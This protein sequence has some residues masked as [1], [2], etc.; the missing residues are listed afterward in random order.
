MKYDL[1]KIMSRAWKIKEKYDQKTKNQLW[2][3][4]DFRELKAEETAL[5]SECLKAAWKE[6]KRAVEL[7]NKFADVIELSEETAAEMAEVETK[8]SMEECRDVQARWNIWS[9]I[10]AY[11]N[12]SCWSRYKNSKRCNYVAL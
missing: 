9:G 8:V 4:N 11:Y 1:K 6:A 10:R 3:H 7:R 12:F 2:N 5:F